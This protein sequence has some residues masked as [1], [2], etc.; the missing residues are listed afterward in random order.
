M[1]AMRDCSVPSRRK[2]V[3][4]KNTAEMSSMLPGGAPWARQVPSKSVNPNRSSNANHSAFGGPPG[5]VA[6]HVAT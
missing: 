6:S 5:N 3:F 2:R 1:H 4:W